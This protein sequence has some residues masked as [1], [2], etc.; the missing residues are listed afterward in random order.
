MRVRNVHARRFAASA[1]AVGQLIDGLS[2]ADDR[3]WPRDRWP[4]MR[5]DRPLG[6]GAVGGHGPIRYTVETYV[7]GRSV[8][9]RFAA[10]H[11]FLGT[12]QYE[13]EALATGGTI[14][15][16]VMT[17]DAVGS[18]RLTWPLV[19]RPLHDALIEDSLDCAAVALGEARVGALWSPVVRVLRAA[20]RTV[21]RIA[22]A[23]QH[24]A[25]ERGA[26]HRG[27]SAHEE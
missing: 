21:G 13:V 26:R 7:P 3:L 8:R 25:G 19:F 5:F 10:P 1:G 16:H 22:H 11:G 23:R 15:R 18:A 27:A 9:F 4:A 2:S 14:L 17:M 12:H 20:L 6:V 24:S